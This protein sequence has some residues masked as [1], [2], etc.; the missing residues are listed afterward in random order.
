MTIRST[1]T[2]I[3]SRTFFRRSWVIGRCVWMPCRAR[4]IAVASM[5]PIQMGRYR[6]PSRSLS[7]TIGWLLGSSTRTPTRFS[8][9]M[10]RAP[11]Y[12][13]APGQATYGPPC[14]VL[15]C[16]FVHQVVAERVRIRCQRGLILH[17]Q[18]ERKVAVAFVLIQ[19]VADHELVRAVEPHE[20]DVQ[21]RDPPH[22]LIQEHANLNGDQLPNRE[23]TE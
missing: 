12:P 4:A 3:S 21:R 8:S 18:D 2:W 13:P 23:N 11:I 6:S 10:A 17:G 19:A 7:S 22:L 9:I 15:P 20:G 16:G 14:P 5:E 1:C